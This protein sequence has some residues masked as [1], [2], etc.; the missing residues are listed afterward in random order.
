MKLIGSIIGRLPGGPPRLV[1]RDGEEELSI[2]YAVDAS[3]LDTLPVIGSFFDDHRYSWFAG[4]GLILR[5]MTDAAHGRHDLRCG[6][7]ICETGSG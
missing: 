5:T 2:T 1:N 4:R 6:T 3:E 7:S